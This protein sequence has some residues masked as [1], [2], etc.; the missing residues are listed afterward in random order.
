MKKSLFVIILL[1]AATQLSFAQAPAD[2]VKT[3]VVQALDIMKNHSINKQKVDWEKLYATTLEAAKDAKTIKDT[4]PAINKAL[5]DLKDN[6][7]R[8][9]PAEV[10][11]AYKEMGGAEASGQKLPMPTGTIVE[12]KY[13]LITVPG[14]SAITNEDQLAF[15]DSIQHVIRKLDEQN[16]KGWIIDLRQNQGG[17]LEPTIAGL[18]PILGEGKSIGWAD[19]DNKI[20]YANYKN[21]M[22]IGLTDSAEHFIK[23]PYTLK[24]Q[25]Q[26]VAVLVS[27]KT[28]SSGEMTAISFRGR[29]HTKIIGTPTQGLTTSNAPRELSDGAWLN[30]TDSRAA[31]RHGKVYGSKLTPDIELVMTENASANSYLYVN[32]AIKHIDKPKQ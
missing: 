32:A 25:G 6:H 18:M 15:V 19:G 24:K 16:P 14:F 17:N 12:G 5:S 7:S 2:S 28:S 22:I 8:L 1:L 30:L 21:G 29:K 27:G 13:A 9:Y 20:R 31:D 11:K 26:P 23:A 3:Y 10:I 4:H